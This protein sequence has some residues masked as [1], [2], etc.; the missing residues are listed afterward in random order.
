MENTLELSIGELKAADTRSVLG[1]RT[2]SEFLARSRLNEYMVIAKKVLTNGFQ[3][4]SKSSK[5]EIIKKV[6]FK[7]KDIASSTVYVPGLSLLK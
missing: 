7:I 4:L 6:A 1:P 5:S 2:S 3:E